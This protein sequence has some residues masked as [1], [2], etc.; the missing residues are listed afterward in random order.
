MT[1]TVWKF[2]RPKQRKPL[3]AC[4]VMKGEELVFESRSVSIRLQTEEAAYWLAHHV[5]A[6]Q[7]IPLQNILPKLF[8]HGDLDDD[9]HACWRGVHAHAEWSNGARRGGLWYCSVSEGNDVR[10]F[11]TADRNDICPKSGKAARWL[12][13]LIMTLAVDKLIDPY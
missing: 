12:C 10:F 6:V 3:W 8:W 2:D 1:I 9:C 4:R 11:H 7:L 13:E 5:E